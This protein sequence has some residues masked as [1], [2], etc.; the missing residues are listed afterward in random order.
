MY[1]IWT[2][3]LSYILGKLFNIWIEW[4]VTGKNNFFNNTFNRVTIMK[5][6]FLYSLS[7]RSFVSCHSLILK[8]GTS[9]TAIVKTWWW[10][11]FSLSYYRFFLCFIPFMSSCPKKSSRNWKLHITKTIKIT[12]RDKWIRVHNSQKQRCF[13]NY[14]HLTYRIL[15]WKRFWNLLLCIKFCYDTHWF[16]VRIWLFQYTIEYINTNLWEILAWNIYKRFDVFHF[17]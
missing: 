4:K 6:Q 7:Q 12:N 17:A 11:C 2:N 10:V 8:I 14:L 15:R 5:M 1:S 16:Y 3:F 9:L 13:R